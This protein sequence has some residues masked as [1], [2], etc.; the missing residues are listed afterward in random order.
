MKQLNKPI[1]CTWED[2]LGWLNNACK[3]KN[4]QYILFWT[5]AYSFQTI[6]FH[7]KIQTEIFIVK[8][9]GCRAGLLARLRKQPLKPL[10]PSIFLTNARSIVH[11]IDELELHPAA[12]SFV[13]WLLCYDHPVDLAASA[14]PG[15]VSSTS[16]THRSDRNKSP[17]GAEEGD[18]VF[19]SSTSGA[20]TQWL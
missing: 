12:N 6:H 16:A 19:M 5:N 10:I 3:W 1:V 8:K 13:S 4:T 14:D 18:C 17:V 11:K 15:C 2:R 20:L 7:V 9:R